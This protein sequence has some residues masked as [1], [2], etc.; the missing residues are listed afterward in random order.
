MCFFRR[1]QENS[2]PCIVQLLETDC[3]PWLVAL[4]FLS[5][6]LLYCK[7]DGDHIGYG[8]KIQEKLSLTKWHLQSPFCGMRGILT[9]SR[10]YDV[11]SFFFFSVLG[12]EPRALY[13]LCKDLTTQ[14]HPQPQDIDIFNSGL[15]RGIFSCYITVTP[16]TLAI[17]KKCIW[18]GE[19]ILK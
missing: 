9:S 7:N 4:H 19:V 5:A 10:C 16:K 6:S 17:S 15:W 12:I 2:F 1:L 11:N 18:T 3:I 14:L 8:K 13:M